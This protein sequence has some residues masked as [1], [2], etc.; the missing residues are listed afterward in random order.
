MFIFRFY[1]LTLILFISPINHADETKIDSRMNFLNKLLNTSTG[2]RQVKKSDDP[3]VKALHQQAQALHDQAR[4][5]FDQ[6]NSK[7]GSALLDQ[8]ART[9]FRAIRLATPQTA[10]MVKEKRDYNKEK[11]S[12]Q[13]LNKAYNRVADEKNFTGKKQINQKVSHFIEIADALSSSSKFVQAK[14]ELDKAYQLLKISIESIRG[15]E[16]LTRTL[17]FK[18]PEE[19]Y[20]Y[21]L[22]RND[23]HSMLVT[24]LVDG[25]NISEY[26][27]KQVDKFTDLANSLRTEAEQSAEHGEFTEAIIMLEQSTKQ[28]VRAIRSAGIFIPG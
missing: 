23:T 13:A 28:L 21:E 16:T 15:G 22:D 17:D 2:A 27:Q 4:N 14:A 11:K 12:V 9:M 19:E 20:H 5:E 10:G 8:S 1:F 24:L 18:T 26:T 3:E 6:G 25:R 7:Q